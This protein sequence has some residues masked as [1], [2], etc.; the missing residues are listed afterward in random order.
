MSVIVNTG[1]TVRRQAKI[2]DASTSHALSVVYADTEH[3]AAFNAL[4]T[5]INTIIDALEANNITA[6]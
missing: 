3:E 4:A 2:T 1:K 5:K 6:A